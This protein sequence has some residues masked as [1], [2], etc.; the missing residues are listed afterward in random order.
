M[1]VSVNQAQVVDACH[2]KECH[3]IQFFFTADLEDQL[4]EFGCSS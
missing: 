1:K 2:G 3:G 4:V